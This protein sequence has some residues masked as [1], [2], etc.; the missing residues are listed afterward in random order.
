[1]TVWWYVEGDKTFGPIERDEVDRLLNAGEIGAESILWHEGMDGWRPLNEVKEFSGPRGDAPPPLPT[2]SDPGPPS[3]PLATRWPR[4]LA[5]IFDVWWETVLVSLLVGAVLGRYSATFVEWING[6]DSGLLFTLLC[7]PLALTLDALVY[8]VAGTT[9]GKAFLRLKVGR[10]DGKPLSFSQYLGRNFS[11]WFSGLGLGIPFVS[12]FTLVNQ[13]GRLRKGQQT[14]YDES[15]GFRV[16]SQVVGASRKTAFGFAFAGLLIVAMM[17]NALEQA[18]RNEAY[19]RSAQENYSWENPV[20]GLTATVESRWAY[21]AE[22]NE[23]GQQVYMFSESA[24]YAL[25]I[26]AAEQVDEYTLNDYVDAFRKSTA[27]DM[28]FYDGGRF[29]EFD[30]RQS[31]EGAGSLVGSSSNRL[32]V[33]IVQL[34]SAFWRVVTIQTKPY[35]Y[36]DAF[37]DQLQK[38]LW[39]TIR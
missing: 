1:M 24:D 36:S 38:V 25:V 7:L 8:Q 23:D 31:W 14:S 34:G 21:S 22:P 18:S 16:R 5:R 2:R 32:K 35:D 30:G 4:Y 15:T 29:L 28:Q 10:L 12:L 27:A 26:L 6:P 13:S 9:P 39:G 11:V 20:T 17:L 33:Q 37:V 3:D 19:L